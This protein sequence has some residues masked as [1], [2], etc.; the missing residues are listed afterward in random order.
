MGK[1]VGKKRKLNTK[2]KAGIIVGIGLIILLMGVM[3]Y[4]EIAIQRTI[5]QEQTRYQ[6]T[7]QP[8]LNY[9]VHI[10]DNEIYGSNILKEGMDYSK[11]LLDYIEAK[12]MIEFQGSEPAQVELNYHIAL[13]LRGYK[14]AVEGNSI[15]WIKNYELKENTKVKFSEQYILEKAAVS[16]DLEKYNS[17][18]SKANEI[19]G[20]QLSSDIIVTLEGDLAINTQYGDLDT[21]ISMQLT[22]PLEQNEFNISKGESPVISDSLKEY[23]EVPIPMNRDK[24]IL[25]LAV[26]CF[27]SILLILIL[28][29]TEA[30]GF[31]DIRTANAKKLLK[32]YSSRIVAL[33]NKTDQ[34]FHQ[35]YEMNTMMDLVKVADEIQKPIYYIYDDFFM[36]NKYSFYVADGDNQYL[37]QLTEEAG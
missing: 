4:R 27:C 10:I 33:H 7:C 18:A 19:L 29:S 31:Y 21:P 35:T 6:Y 8:S 24:V 28:L 11:N 3:V 20:M 25:F 37:Y 34:V 5:T 26:I 22:I 2:I 15:N 1:I 23:H 30:P 9:D 36:L 17:F 14:A 16:F 13:T 32:N 12:F